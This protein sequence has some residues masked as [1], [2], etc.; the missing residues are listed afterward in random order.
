[1]EG[2]F[3]LNKSKFFS[4]VCVW[5][6]P[7]STF[8]SGENMDQTIAALFEYELRKKGSIHEKMKES[9]YFNISLWKRMRH[10]YFAV[11]LTALNDSSW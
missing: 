2:L 4:G 8:Q 1:M 9:G 3:I 6:V 5:E 10:I 7:L 11:Y